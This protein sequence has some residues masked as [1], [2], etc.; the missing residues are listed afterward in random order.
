MAISPNGGFFYGQFTDLTGGTW[1]VRISSGVATGG[2]WG[3]TLSTALPKWPNRGSRDK[4]PGVYG[5]AI[6][7]GVEHRAFLPMPSSALAAAKYLT[8]TFSIGGQAY[9]ITGMRGEHK[10]KA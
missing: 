1:R 10:S 2:G 4:L 8:G 7:G 9:T 6:V 5:E 3:L